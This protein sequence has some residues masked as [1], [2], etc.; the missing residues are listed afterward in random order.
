MLGAIFSLY[1][2]TKPASLAPEAYWHALKEL[3]DAILIETLNAFYQCNVEGQS[4]FVAPSAHQIKQEAR[5]LASHRAKLNSYRTLPPPE[6]EIDEAQRK[7]MGRRLVVFAQRLT[8]GSDEVQATR[9]QEKRERA[10]AAHARLRNREGKDQWTVT[11]DGVPISRS[12][13]DSP[14]LQKAAAPV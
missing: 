14:I 12:L 2:S 6:P 11:E 8:E 3:P 1:P 10:L 9:A 5:R 13:L 4:P 7:E